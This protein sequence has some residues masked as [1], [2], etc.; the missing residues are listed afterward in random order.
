MILVIIACSCI[1]RF[2]CCEVIIPDQG[3]EFVNQIQEELYQR[4]MQDLLKGGSVIL[5]RAKFWGARPL[6]A[7]PRLFSI[8]V[9][10]TACP[11][12]LIDLFLI[13]YS[14]EAY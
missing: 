4:R 6:L 13:G 14:A 9:R 11:T 5:S 2:G 12:S 10:G 3:R 7:K 1:N 8:V